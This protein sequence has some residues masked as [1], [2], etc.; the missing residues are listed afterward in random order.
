MKV[1]F[2]TNVVLDLMLDREPFS[3][4]A[5]Q[6]LS[7]VEIG[8]LT[9]FLGATTVTTIS[10]LLSKVVGKEKSREKIGKLLF[11]F[12]IAPVDISVLQNAVQSKL[13]DF[14]DAVL[15]EAGKR[16]NAKAIITRDNRGFTGS[17]IRV[18][19]PDEFL[20]ILCS[21]K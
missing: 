21:V 1:L 18:Y 10:Y 16:V 8:E 6:L 14:E 7:K 3:T 9:G 4:V 20:F 11:L 2:D 5:A 15:Y 17:S 19:S 12:E 13:P